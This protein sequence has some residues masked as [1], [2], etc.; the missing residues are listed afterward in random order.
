M[1]K[2][3]LI[4]FPILLIGLKILVNKEILL[5]KARKRKTVKILH[6]LSPMYKLQL[7]LFKD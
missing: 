3:V 7:P 4:Q 1:A 2:A 6:A 5:A